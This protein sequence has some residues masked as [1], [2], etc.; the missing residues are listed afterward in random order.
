MA[1]IAF[2]PTLSKI[3]PENLSSLGENI[4]FSKHF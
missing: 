3:F 4:E 2:Q 1:E